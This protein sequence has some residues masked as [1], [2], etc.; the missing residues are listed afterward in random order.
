MGTQEQ[1]LVPQGAGRFHSHENRDFDSCSAK[2]AYPPHRRFHKHFR[3]GGCAPWLPLQENETALGA[4][5]KLADLN[6][7]GIEGKSRHY[8]KAQPLK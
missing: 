8:F 6:R 7:I 5:G 1:I 3:H 4:R 2:N